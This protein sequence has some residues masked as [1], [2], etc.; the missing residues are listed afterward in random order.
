[1]GFSDAEIEV[2][3]FSLELSEVP[4]SLWEAV[5]KHKLTTEGSTGA[6][7]EY[8]TAMAEG[9]WRLGAALYF[10]VV[11]RWRVE[12]FVESNDVS[13]TRHKLLYANHLR[14]GYMTMH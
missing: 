4:L 12:H 14:Q 9:C 1:M 5:T 8:I 13:E 6:L 10:Q 7:E 3:C 2:A 11:W